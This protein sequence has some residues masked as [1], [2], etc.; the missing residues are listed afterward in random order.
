M[1]NTFTKTS[2]FYGPTTIRS[3]SSLIYCESG[4]YNS[5]NKLASFSKNAFVE[6]NKQKLKADSIYYDKGIGIAR[7]YR[8]VA[9]IDT[10]QDMIVTGDYSIYYEKDSISIITGN[11]LL[12]Q[13]NE[14]DTL[15]L[16]GD[17]LYSA[18]D[19]TRK[20]RMLHAF[21]KVKFYKADMQG[22]CDSLVFSDADSTIKLFR[23]PIIWSNE[24]QMTAKYIEIK[25]YNGKVHW[26]RFD[27]NA[28]II[29]EV[30]TVKYNQ[31]KGNN[32]FG[33]F[34]ESKLYRIDV[35]QN[36]QTIYYAKEDNGDMIGVNRANC[37]DM[38]I[39]INDNKVKRIAFKTKTSATLYPLDEISADELLLKDFSWKGNIRPMKKEDVFV[40]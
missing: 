9:I 19:S 33:Y 28:F 16:H 7:A 13:Y 11:A 8:N 31:I 32:M 3:D 12:T 10:T 1:H 38:A 6:N 17:T 5:E 2:Y 25:N 39:Y 36:G 34:N 15:Y 40:W 29:S 4:W 30:D 21:H 14:K 26:M 35:K 37:E 24:N 20:H 23:A 22:Q 18:Y 27:E